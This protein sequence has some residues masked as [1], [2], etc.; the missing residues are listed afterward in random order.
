MSLGQFKCLFVARTHNSK[1]YERAFFLYEF[2]KFQ[3]FKNYKKVEHLKFYFKRQ[4][5]KFLEF[6]QT[7]ILT[8]LPHKQALRGITTNIQ[9]AQSHCTWICVGSVRLQPQ[10]AHHLIV[11][12]KNPDWFIGMASKGQNPGSSKFLKPNKGHSR[13]YWTAAT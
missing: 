2:S 12:G 11:E 8:I 1:P 9:T 7:R 4:Y 13:F 10:W 5:L 6:S 3:H